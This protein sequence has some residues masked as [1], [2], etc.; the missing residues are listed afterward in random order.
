MATLTPEAA[1]RIARIRARRLARLASLPSFRA[2]PLPEGL[3][4]GEPETIDD[5]EAVA[6]LAEVVGRVLVALPYEIRRRLAGAVIVAVSELYR[7][8]R[9]GEIGLPDEQAET[10]EI[11]FTLHRETVGLTP[12]EERALAVALLARY[13][14]RMR[15]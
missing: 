9:L 11:A 3:A 6:D 2:D 14:E 4:E 13:V 12:D 10:A 15:H 1:T 8:A 5:E 7:R